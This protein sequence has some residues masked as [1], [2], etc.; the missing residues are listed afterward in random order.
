MCAM[1]QFDVNHRSVSRVRKCLDLHFNTQLTHFRTLLS[2][3]ATVIF[4]ALFVILL[5]GIHVQYVLFFLLTYYI[6]ILEN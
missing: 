5:N 3:T 2:R 1:M 4:T 6:Q